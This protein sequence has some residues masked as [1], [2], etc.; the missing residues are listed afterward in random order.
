MV[1]IAVICVI[2]LFLTTGITEMN[3]QKE[4][5][6]QSEVQTEYT[7]QDME[8]DRDQIIRQFNQESQQIEQDQKDLDGERIYTTDKKQKQSK[9]ND[10]SYQDS[11]IK[12]S[13]IGSSSDAL[14][15]VFQK[16]QEALQE[17]RNEMVDGGNAVVDAIGSGKQSLSSAMGQIESSGSNSK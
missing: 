10:K 2:A 13:E 17:S 9:Q 5:Q 14:D 1:L 7:L 12:K 15:D 6:P 11:Q 8:E 3:K 16:Q 4:L